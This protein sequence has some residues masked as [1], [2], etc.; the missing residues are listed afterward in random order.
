[1][2]VRHYNI[3]PLLRPFVREICTVESDTSAVTS[4]PIRVLPDTCVELFVNTGEPQSIASSVGKIA[5]VSRSFVTSRMNQFMDVRTF[6]SVSYVSVCFWSGSAYSFFPVPMQAVANQVV[7]LQDLWGR[8][9][10]EMQ[11]SV[12]EAP[13]MT[14]RVQ[15]I[16]Q[17]LIRQLAKASQYDLG[18][19]RC[20]DQ[21]SQV[22]G[23]LSLEELANR[24]GISNR[25]L[26]RRFNQ[27]VGLA[28][29][30]FA[31]ITAFKHALAQ[32]K[33]SPDYNLTQ[34]AYDSGYY[35]QSH[36]IHACRE[37]SG[38]SPRQLLQANYIL[39]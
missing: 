11:Q 30:E 20:I 21:I 34:I 28:P 33:I 27:C 29:K 17:H 7:D 8:S 3:A 12:D 25:Q 32:L 24:I 2:Q 39:C 9:A 35:D 36:F 23:Q 26:I 22:H 10:D 15:C 37:Y 13:T 19:A 18:V 14:Q 38:L 4:D 5:H 31:R 6:S 1:M 16:Q